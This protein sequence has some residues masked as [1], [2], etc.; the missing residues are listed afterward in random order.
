[1][2]LR[3][4]VLMLLNHFLTLCIIFQDIFLPFPE[5][6]QILRVDF[7]SVTQRILIRKSVN[8]SFCYVYFP[9]LKGSAFRV[10]SSFFIFL[11]SN[12]ARK[13]SSK[14]IFHTD[15]HVFLCQGAQNNFCILLYVLHSLSA[16]TFIHG[17]F[18]LCYCFPSS[19]PSI[20]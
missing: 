13:E 17:F 8:L 11:S 6:H 3:S 2:Y 16:R 10:S 20:Y 5:F 19:N 15:S 14:T 7:F 1:M 12:P 4:F 9:M 18:R